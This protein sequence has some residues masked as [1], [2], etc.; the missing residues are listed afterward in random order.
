MNLMESNQSCKRFGQMRV[1][2]IKQL[3]AKETAGT[4]V[5]ILAALLA[6]VWVNA[7][8]VE[9][10]D[11]VF[12][13]ARGIFALHFIINEGLM[14]L[15]FMLVGFEIKRELLDGELNTLKKASLPLLCALGGMLVPALI[16]WL[17]SRHDPIAVRG[18]AIPCATDIAFSLAALRLVLSARQ[19]GLRIFLSAL[20]IFDDLGGILIIALFYNMNMAPAYLVLSTLLVGATY[21]LGKSG[22]G[23][24]PMYAL[25]AVALWFSFFW[26]GIHPTMSGAVFAFALPMASPSIQRYSGLLLRTERQILILCNVAVLPLF[27]LANLGFDLSELSL[28]SVLSAPSAGTTLGLAVGKPLGI[29]LTALLAVRLGIAHLPSKSTWA[30]IVGVSCLAGIGFT[31]SL[32]IATLAFDGATSDYLNEAKLG[33]L[34]GSVLSALLG[35]AVFRLSSARASQ[36][37]AS[38]I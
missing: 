34:V 4:Y 12:S 17:F 27:A 23:Y 6:L 25:L 16:Y 19:P 38:C 18:W 29:C 32:F 24:L 8:G 1:K 13:S 9:S 37:I 28:S 15:F 31:V 35:L 2:R 14:T 22:H 21:A 10:Y 33:V 11:W 30:S 7:L 36:G 20:A 3:F 26:A 5:L